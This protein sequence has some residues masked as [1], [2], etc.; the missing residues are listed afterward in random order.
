M[1][2]IGLAASKMAKGNFALYNFWVV[3]ISSTV[4]MFLFLVA[5]ISIFLALVILAA[6]VKGIMPTEFEKSWQSMLRLC[7]L[8]LTIV[9]SLFNLFAIFKNI[10]F[11]KPSD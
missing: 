11:K 2:R 6:V 1:E 9:V 7:I 8:A 3:V 4:S 10:R 5:G